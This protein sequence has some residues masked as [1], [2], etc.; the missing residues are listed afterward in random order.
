MNSAMEVLLYGN[1]QFDR[2]QKGILFLIIVPFML[3]VFVWFVSGIRSHSKKIIVDTMRDENLK[4]VG[5]DSF[6]MLIESYRFILPVAVFLLMDYIVLFFADGLGCSLSQR[7]TLS[8]LV[9]ISLVMLSRFLCRKERNVFGKYHRLMVLF[10]GDVYILFMLVFFGGDS[11]V[12]VYTILPVVV[13]VTYV[14]VIW[15]IQDM[16]LLKKYIYKSVRIMKWIRE[17]SAVL[18]L[19]YILAGMIVQNVGPLT[20]VGTIY[21]VFWLALCFIEHMIIEMRDIAVWVKYKVVLSGEEIYTRKKVIQYNCDKV[22]IIPE[23]GGKRIVDA[24]EIEYIEYT[25]ENCSVKKNKYRVVCI[26][27]DGETKEYDRFKYSNEDWIRL[28]ENYMDGCIVRVV[29]DK[30]IKEIREEVIL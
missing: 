21:I 5:V 16:P 17:V 1:E 3:K 23:C 6:W 11:K 22:K 18:F 26:Q 13:V 27:R 28:Y 30:R 12:A 7:V 20:Y 19:L 4:Q 10:L 2:L 25:L 8:F 24:E 29:E 9:L 15:S 14:E